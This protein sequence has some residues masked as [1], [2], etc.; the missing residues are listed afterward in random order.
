M[1]FLTS[2]LVVATPTTSSSL[3]L[4]HIAYNTPFGMEI[5]MSIF[6]L[7]F[8]LGLVN[9]NA[10]L[11]P[12]NL[13]PCFN[14]L[15]MLNKLNV[16]SGTSATSFIMACPICIP[17]LLQITLGKSPIAIDFST[18]LLPMMMLKLPL[19]HACLPSQCHRVSCPSLLLSN[20]WLC[21]LLVGISCCSCH[22]TTHFIPCTQQKFNMVAF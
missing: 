22:H 4:M 19:L 10:S 13:H 11:V 6:I 12:P 15:E 18:Y 5:L 16:Q 2:W 9:T 3:H 8:L 20:G 7:V 17:W 21:Q 1:S 14:C